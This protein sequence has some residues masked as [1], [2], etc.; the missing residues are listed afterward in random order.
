VLV[1][2]DAVVPTCAKTKT[3]KDAT[4]VTVHVS[5]KAA[6]ANAK[7][8]ADLTCLLKGVKHAYKVVKL[9]DAMTSVL[10]LSVLQVIQDRMTAN[11]RTVKENALN[12]ITTDLEK[13]KS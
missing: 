4:L 1:K 9:E 5:T 12:C 11:A 8:C 10:R 7:S 6:Q 13:E 3:L 2:R